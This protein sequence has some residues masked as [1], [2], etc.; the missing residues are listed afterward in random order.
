MVCVLPVRVRTKTWNLGELVEDMWDRGCECLVVWCNLFVVRESES[1]SESES[2]RGD[3][4]G[5]G[6]EPESQSLSRDDIRI[7]LIKPYEKEWFLCKL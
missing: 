4:D 5:G 3:K 2:E 7:Q 6:F 1:E